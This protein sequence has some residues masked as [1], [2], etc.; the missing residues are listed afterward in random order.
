MFVKHKNKWDLHVK[1]IFFL[2]VFNNSLGLIVLIWPLSNRKRKWFCTGLINWF[3][4]RIST[5]VINPY[6]LV[7]SVEV[8]TGKSSK[9]FVMCLT[10]CKTVR[11]KQ[12][13]YLMLF[14]VFW[15]PLI[16]WSPTFIPFDIPIINAVMISMIFLF[17]QWIGRLDSSKRVLVLCLYIL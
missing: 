17:A 16:V 3:E 9:I 6:Y 5:L 8:V 1:Y 12:I 14:R 2:V 4:G 7:K 10:L 13:F 11:H 15:F